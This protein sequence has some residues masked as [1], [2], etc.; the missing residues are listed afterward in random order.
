[1]LLFVGLL[2]GYLCLIVDWLSAIDLVGLCCLVLGCC[3]VVWLL[4]VDYN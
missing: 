2:P 3:I 1:M 4:I